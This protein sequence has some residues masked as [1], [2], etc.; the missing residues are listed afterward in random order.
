[1]IDKP[2]RAKFEEFP[3]DGA[4]RADEAA[5]IPTV[6]AGSLFRPGGHAYYFLNFRTGRG[7]SV[8]LPHL[9]VIAPGLTRF[10]S[11]NFP[12]AP[13]PAWL[14]LLTKHYHYGFNL[15]EQLLLMTVPHTVTDLGNGRFI[16]SLWSYFGCILVD[17]CD[18]S[19]VYK[20]LDRTADNGV[21]GSKLWYEADREVLLYMTYSLNQSMRRAA[22]TSALVTSRIGEY[23]IRTGERRTLWEGTFADYMHDLVLSRD[24]RYLVACEMG[25]HLDREGNLI[26]SK[27]LVR[28][29]HS[30]RDW[31]LREIANPA[32]AQFDPEDTQTLYFSNHNFRFEHTRLGELLQKRTYSIKFLGPASVHKFRI[33]PD[34]PQPVGVFTH[35]ELYRLTNFHVFWHRGQKLLVAFGAPNFLYVADAE[36]LQL[37]RRIEVS[38]GGEPV[39]IGTFCPSRDGEK[40]HVQT[41]QSFHT[42]DIATGLSEYVREL[43]IQHTCSNHMLVTANTHW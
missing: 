40:L 34:G 23:G 26:A 41:T 32:H 33:G 37:L 11:A 20:L 42:V 8:V 9:A 27:V 29:L 35:P 10:A 36:S 38:H 43:P 25:R 3:I 16:V 7:I 15:L 14:P 12:S 39:Y 4:V 31:V 30:G 5:I 19:V 6:R 1:M 22:D 28:D 13:V 18:R 17:L 21:L 2:L 24:R